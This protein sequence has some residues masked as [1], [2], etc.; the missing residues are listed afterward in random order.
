MKK[1]NI[2]D[3]ATEAF[4][5]WA[6]IGCPAYEDILSYQNA[7]RPAF[8]D[9]EKEDIRACD[10]CFRYFSESGHTVICDAVREVYMTKPNQD[11]GKNEISVRV[12]RFSMK[13]PA[14]ER[15]VYY[16]LHQARVLFA[17]LRGLR[18]DRFDLQ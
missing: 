3:Y 6:S 5:Y 18:L 12:T 10:A 8:S 4:R 2:R 13:T 15:Q 11:I 14:S 7:E 9:A 17:E 16:W 1:D